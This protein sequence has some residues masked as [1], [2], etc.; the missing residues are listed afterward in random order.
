MTE[1]VGRSWECGRLVRI[2]FRTSAT[3]VR[4]NRAA[5]ATHSLG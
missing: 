5:C 3:L 2:D 1:E 4:P